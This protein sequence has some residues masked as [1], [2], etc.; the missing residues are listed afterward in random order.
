[1]TNAAQD[2]IDR[3][4]AQQAAAQPQPEAEAAYDRATANMSRFG[5]E[6]PAEAMWIARNMGSF[7]FAKAMFDDVGRYGSLTP[8]K[9]A[10]I[11]KCMAHE[12]AHG[13]EHAARASEPRQAIVT[14]PIEAA[15]ARAREAGVRKPLGLGDFLFSPAPAHGRNPGAIYVK[16]AAD[17]VY[18]GAV[19]A[20]EFHRRFECSPAEAEAIADACADPRNAAFAFSR[21]YA[22]CAICH[23]TL[24]AKRSV[25]NGIGPVC[26]KKYGW[27]L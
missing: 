15:F 23:A 11:A 8:N 13:A 20:G 2:V 9:L 21:R 12:T 6:H 24:T 27:N 25:D 4:L 1:M 17:D 26:L 10:G 22:R 19:K 5:R 3:Y 14:A 7:S 18:L 16:R